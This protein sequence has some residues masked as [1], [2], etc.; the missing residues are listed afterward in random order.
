MRRLMVTVLLTLDGVIE[1][2]EEPREVGMPA[3]RF[4]SRMP[5]ACGSSSTRRSLHGVIAM[6]DNLA[7][8]YG[9]V[10]SATPGV[11]A[12]KSKPTSGRP[13]HRVLA[14]RDSWSSNPSAAGTH[15][16]RASGPCPTP[17]SVM[18]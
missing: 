17:R 18:S 1:N 14:Y 16:F 10:V 3:G 5:T 13:A 4:G 15:A 7:S 8:T 2:P 6:I 9:V 11:E 12:S